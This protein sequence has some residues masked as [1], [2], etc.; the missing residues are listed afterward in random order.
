ME[1]ANR[2]SPW[3]YDEGFLMKP[4]AQTVS[5][6]FEAYRVW[7]GISTETGSRTRRGVCLT[8]KKPA[9]RR[10]AEGLLAVWEWGNACRFTTAFEILPGATIFVG[11]VRP[12]HNDDASLGAPGSQIFVEGTLE[13]NP[14]IRKIGLKQPLVDD[15]GPYFIVPNRDPKLRHRPSS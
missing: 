12:G 7:G 6:R 4:V 8:F 14:F 2:T 10:Q 3:W 13:Q 1:I 11:W 5:R 9:S 15:V